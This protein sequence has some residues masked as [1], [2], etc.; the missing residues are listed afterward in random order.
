MNAPNLPDRF[1]IAVAAEADEDDLVA[2]IVYDGQQI[3]DVRRVGGRWEVTFYC[4]A[5]DRLRLPADEFVAVMQDAL[6]RLQPS[7]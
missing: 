6:R 3:A 5:S 1:Y 4:P 2:D 7:D